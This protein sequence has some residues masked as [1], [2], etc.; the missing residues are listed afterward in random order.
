MSV[1]GPTIYAQTAQAAA[2]LSGKLYHMVRFSGAGLV[3]QSSLSTD[4]D[5][6]GVLQNT[7]RSGEFASI[8]RGGKGRIVAGA[9]ASVF[10]LLTTNSSGRAVAV[11]SGS[12]SIVAGR[13]L[14]AP[15][16]DG[17]IV[18]AEVFETP[19]VWPGLAI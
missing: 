1:A 12:N 18:T 17:D 16:A 6:A 15:G 8:E 13:F 3:N 7:P 19:Y 11:A 2:D 9:S 5:Y 10:A 4:L 14:E